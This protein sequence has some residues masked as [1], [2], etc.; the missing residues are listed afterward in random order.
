MI[1]EKSNRKSIAYLL[2]GLTVLVS[3]IHI[4]QPITITPSGGGERFGASMLLI[5]FACLIPYGN[6]S[7]RVGLGWMFLFLT[8][9]NL[10]V[11]L[12]YVREINGNT[13][14][15]GFITIFLGVL[16]YLLLRSSSLRIFEENCRK[17]QLTKT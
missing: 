1:S 6:R 2:V 17:Q 13:F 11:F 8:F 9:I 3:V 5:F 14:G 12:A 4:W 10:L 7:A 16:G 15:G